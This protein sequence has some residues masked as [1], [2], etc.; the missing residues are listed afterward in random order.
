M[1]PRKRAAQVTRSSSSSASKESCCVCCQTISVG[2]DESLF[3]GGVC[4]QW[5]HRYCAGVS[6]KYY[7]D[8]VENDTP[9][10]CFACCQARHKREIATLKDRVELLMKEIADLRSSN[11]APPE[12]QQATSMNS[13]HIAN[14]IS[15]REVSVAT[16]LV[17]DSSRVAAQSNLDRKFNVVVF[18]IDVPKVQQSPPVFSPISTM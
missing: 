4:Q 5:L 18:G 8:I 2:R 7:R 6:V 1:P 17:A 3:C 13:A 14:K 12:D 9:F 15:T 16:P 10:S 11:V